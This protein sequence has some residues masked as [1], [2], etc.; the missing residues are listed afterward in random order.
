MRPRT[1]VLP[2]LLDDLLGEVGDDGGRWP[3][4]A[5]S[6]YAAF[7]ERLRALG[8]DIWVDTTRTVGHM[9]RLTFESR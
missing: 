9:G 4:V 6:E 2:P 1:G 3:Q 7:A 8:K 5:T